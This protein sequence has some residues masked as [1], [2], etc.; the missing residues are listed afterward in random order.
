MLIAAQTMI[1]RAVVVVQLTERS[2]P[3]PYIGLQFESNNQQNF[4]MNIVTVNYGKDENKEKEAGNGPI[5]KQKIIF[6]HDTKLLVFY[7][8]SF[9]AAQNFITE[10]C[11][12]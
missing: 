7:I 10:K 6:L 11:E 9:Q 8:R 5:L 12:K 4:V 3:I 2:L 1:I